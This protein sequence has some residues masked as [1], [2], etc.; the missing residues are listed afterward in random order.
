M[1]ELRTGT[2]SIYKIFPPKQNLNEL[3]SGILV[4]GP[5]EAAEIA[6]LHWQGKLTTP[7]SE[8]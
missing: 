8:N 5:T 7:R 6:Q 3:R 1:Q 4:R 2:L